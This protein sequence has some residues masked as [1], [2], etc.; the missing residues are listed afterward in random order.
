[1]K[2]YLSLFIVLMVSLSTFAQSWQDT[3]ALIEKAMSRYQPQNPG[4][5]LSISRNETIIFSKA[6]GMADVEH[7]IPLALNFVT[8]AGSVSKQF[9]AAAILLLEQQGKL[10]L[11]DDVRQ[12]IPELPDYGVTIKLEQM[13]HHT[14]GLRDWGSVADL[15]GWPR[16]TKTYNNDDALEIIA[17]QKRLNNIPGA[18][19]IYSN[20]NYNLLAIIVQ[21]ISGLSLADFTKKNIFQPAGMMHTEWRDNHN[22]IVPNRA[23]AY[24]LTSKGYETDMPNE[25]VYGN[26]GLLTTTEDLLKWNQYYQ[27]GK[28]GNPSLLLKQVAVVPF[29]N[30]VKNNY[31][32]GLNINRTPGIESISHSGSTAG[33]R[34]NLEYFPNLKMSIAFLSNTSQFDTSAINTATAIR[35][36]FVKN[37]LPPVENKKAFTVVIAPQQLTAFTGWYR[38]DRN[39]NGMQIVLK[40]KILM[41]ANGTTLT[42]V[43]KTIFIANTNRLIFDDRGLQYITPAKDSIRYSKVDSANHSP[44]A[45][46]D[47]IG[48]YY[49]EE[50]RSFMVVSVKND[51][52]K[53]HIKPGWD[54][55]LIATYK[56]GF[57]VPD[58]GGNLYFERN[59]NNQCVRMK[60]SNGRA[61]NVEFRKV[62]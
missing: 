21:R 31:G 45:M 33:Y 15:S 35:N 40:D 2:K 52:L 57:S 42:A 30:G 51:T 12:Y 24:A 56:D 6:W 46:N 18:E 54:F 58:L 28:F 60:I 5:Q 32:A 49:S 50:T 59:N 23:I 36:I 39:G 43:D 47:Y 37:V 38:N 53:I 14:S 16:S 1:M 27:A 11:N 3:V 62:E 17:L 4:C 20:S 19:Y 41:M 48:N 25:D 8:E 22:R 29:I 7:A 34:A 61:R 26:G 10:S 44:A 55:P 9:T 13:M